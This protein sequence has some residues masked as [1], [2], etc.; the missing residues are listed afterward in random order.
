[1][2][3]MFFAIGAALALAGADICIKLA[4]GKLSNSLGLFLYGSCTF[5]TGL[6]W[7]LWQRISGVALRAEPSGILAAVGVGVCFSA[8]TVG[9]YL[10]FAAGAPISLASPMIRLAG[11]LVASLVGLWA[12]GELFT[13]RY[14]AGALLTCI[15]VYLMVTR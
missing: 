1:M 6:S 3:W 4:A 15:G 2:P 10:T 11:L 7:V 14:A 12:F 8:V 13:W 5:L 9:L